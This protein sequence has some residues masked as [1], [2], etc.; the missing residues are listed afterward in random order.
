MVKSAFS[1]VSTV[2]TARAF[3]AMKIV[4]TRLRNRMEDN[5]LSSYLLTYVDKDIARDF[6][7]DSIIDAFYIM[8]ERRAQL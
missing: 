3:S 8:K 7:V 2:T 5:F 6:D 4:K 1:S